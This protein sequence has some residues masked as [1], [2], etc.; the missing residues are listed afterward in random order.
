[1]N[2][3]FITRIKYTIIYSQPS[4]HGSVNDRKRS[5]WILFLKLQVWIT[6]SKKVL[7]NGVHDIGIKMS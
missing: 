4:Y 5:V 3:K 1:M 2:I 7:Q 6:L